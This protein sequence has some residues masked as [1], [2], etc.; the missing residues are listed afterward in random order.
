MRSPIEERT[1]NFYQWERMG[2]GWKSYPYPVHLEPAFAPFRFLNVTTP[3]ADDG[4]HH[5]FLSGLL[6]RFSKSRQ[7]PPPVPAPQIEEPVPE[8]FEE[9]GEPVELRVIL[10][11][12]LS[13]TAALSEHWLKSFATLRAPVSLELVGSSGRVS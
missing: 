2:R 13:V 5:T 6:E 11:S 1:R 10:P 4:R 3:A 8:P 12:D 9:D 7:V